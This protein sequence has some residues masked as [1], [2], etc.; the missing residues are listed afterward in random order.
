MIELEGAARVIFR[1]SGTEPK[2][3]VYLEV[4]GEPG[5]EG[6]DDALTDLVEAVGAQLG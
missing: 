1:P 5:E 6:L 3:K 4:A 2:L